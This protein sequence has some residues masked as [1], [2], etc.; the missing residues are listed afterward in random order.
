[1][2]LADIITEE[3]M[4]LYMVL[5]EDQICKIL[6]MVNVG[7]VGVPALTSNFL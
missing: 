5:D 3:E 2:R 4:C 7:V 1:V 6:D